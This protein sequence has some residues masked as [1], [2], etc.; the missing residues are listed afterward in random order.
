MCQPSTLWFSII[1]ARKK[2]VFCQPCFGFCL[3]SFFYHFWVNYCY[4]LYIVFNCV[5]DYKSIL[6]YGSFYNCQPCLWFSH[7]TLFVVSCRSMS[8]QAFFLFP[9]KQKIMRHVD[10][11]LKCTLIWC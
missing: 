7:F 5:R 2:I 8:Y 1:K 9:E 3:L 10:V 4:S 6:K 11:Q